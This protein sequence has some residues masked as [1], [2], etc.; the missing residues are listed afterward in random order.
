MEPTIVEL[1]AIHLIGISFN[2]EEQGWQFV[3][4]LWY[5]LCHRMAGLAGVA[6]PGR[7]YGYVFASERMPAGVTGIDTYLAGVEAPEG[8]PTPE[9]LSSATVPAGL[10]AVFTVEGGLGDIG[11]AYDEITQGWLPAAPYEEARC[12]AVEVY[13]ER[14]VPSTDSRFE[15]RVAIRPKG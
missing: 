5:G 3:P 14:F 10:Y 13:D 1:P 8:T 11:R 9:G 7:T 6:R 12:G 15:I 2:P 4:T